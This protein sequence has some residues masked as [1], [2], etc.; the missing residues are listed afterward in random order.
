MSRVVV[1]GLGLITSLGN[2]LATNWEALTQGKSGVGP[3]TAYDSTDFRVHFAAEIKNFDPTPYMD[4]KEARR[5]DP[6]EQLAIAT[7]RQALNQAELKISGENADDIGVYIG[8]GIGGLV[9]LH[10][11]FRVLHDKGPSRISPFFI[12]MMIIDGAPGIVS[13]LTGARGPNWAAVSACATSGNTIGEA[14]ETIRRGDVLA[15]IAG[16]AE[17]AVQPIAMSAFDNMTALSRTNEKP[18]EA[19]RPFDALR[20][21]FV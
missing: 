19:S 6:Y 18:Q 8:S 4:R 5:N 9:T 13:I 1:T 16:G 17:K 2:D 12:N 11:Q 14:F 7:S 21:G 3:I 10:D 15:M 20:D